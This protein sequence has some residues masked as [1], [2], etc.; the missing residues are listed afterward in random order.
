LENRSEQENNFYFKLIMTNEISLIPK[1]SLILIFLLKEFVGL[2]VH[3]NWDCSVKHI[4]QKRWVD[5][6]F[7][8]RVFIPFF[9][10]K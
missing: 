9:H 3:A 4:V 2:I 1:P 5:G 6:G 8:Q 7:I 10:D